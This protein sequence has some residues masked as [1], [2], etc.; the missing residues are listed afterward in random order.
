MRTTLTIEDDVAAQ[1]EALRQRERRSL[2]AVVNDA[3]RRG[4]QDMSAERKPAREPFKTKSFDTGRLL[5]PSIDKISEVLD[6][7]DSEEGK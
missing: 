6:W 4:L 5:V 1:L 3:L 7:L 2:K